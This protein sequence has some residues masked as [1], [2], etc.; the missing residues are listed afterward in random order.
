MAAKAL[1]QAGDVVT[2][3]N[4]WRASCPGEGRG[5]LFFQEIPAASLAPWGTGTLSEERHPWCTFQGRSPTQLC[6]LL[7]APFHQLPE[8]LVLV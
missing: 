6:L 5:S 2:C 1:G 8:L 7:L 3:S 4:C